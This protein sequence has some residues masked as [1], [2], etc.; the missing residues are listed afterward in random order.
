MNVPQSQFLA[1]D[2]PL[3]KLGSS[4]AKGISSNQDTGLAM[5]VCQYKESESY[6]WQEH[7]LYQW[8]GDKALTLEAALDRA[9]KSEHDGKLHG[10]QYRVG[11]ERLARLATIAEDH[12]E[13]FK[14]A[15]D[16]NEIYTVVG[17]IIAQVPGAGI[18]A[19]YDITNRI[20]SYFRYNQ[21]VVRV[22]AGAWEGA[23]VLRLKIQNGQVSLEDLPL[24]L[25][26]LGAM[27]VENF[28]CIYKDDLKQLN[29]LKTNHAN[30]GA[31]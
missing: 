11:R 9:F 25:R 23:T 20:G 29:R 2:R 15:R 28:L 6:Q 22:H 19:H 13:R 8:Y 18:L 21:T 24:E 4:C 12:V 27:H 1:C 3:V 30:E 10:H 5:L 26:S 16:W 14:D 31:S 17:D 7:D